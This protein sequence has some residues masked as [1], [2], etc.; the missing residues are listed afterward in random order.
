M[1]TLAAIGVLFA[2]PMFGVITAFGVASDTQL[3]NIARHDVVQTLAL[4]P[5]ETADDNNQ[6]YRYSE[7]IQRGDTVAG[8]LQRLHVDDPEAFDFL[9]KTPAA[10]SIVQL[11]PGRNIQAV[12]DSEGELQ[13]LRYLHSPD[14]YLQ[15]T[16]QANGFYAEEKKLQAT[17]QPVYRAGVIKSSL[18]GATDEANIP[19]AIANQIARVFSTDID[20]HIDL[21]RGD[22]F[23]VVYEMLYQDGE[24][25]GP[26][27]VLSAEFINNGKKFEAFLFVDAEG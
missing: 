2:F 9:R 3:E 6:Q 22:R 7:R 11:R 1:R 25:I 10:R 26:G 19:D 20:F 4:P 5:L 17:T 24:Y 8:L 14:Q 13:S 27:R 15:V 18:Y 23:S 21:R 16:R 12:I